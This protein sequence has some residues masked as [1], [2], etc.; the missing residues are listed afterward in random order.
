MQIGLCQ[1]QCGEEGHDGPG[2]GQREEG[3]VGPGE[4]LLLDE[5]VR[6]LAM[7]LEGR[8]EP[9]EYEKIMFIT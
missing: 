3:P 1:Y 9:G 2:E 7:V 5:E 8:N 6:V 4:G